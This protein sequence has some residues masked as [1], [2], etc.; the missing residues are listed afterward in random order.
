MC[1]H[2]NSILVCTDYSTNIHRDE[3]QVRKQ[4]L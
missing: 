1:T 3:G 4:Q 2:D